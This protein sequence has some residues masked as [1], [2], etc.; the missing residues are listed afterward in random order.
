[1]LRYIFKNW[2][3][4]FPPYPRI[5]TG[6]NQL[7][8]D[9]KF[10]KSCL[11][12]TNINNHTNKLLGFSYDN[13]MKNSIRF[14]WRCNND[15]IE[16]MSYIHEDSKVRYDSICDIET[17]KWYKGK[18][19]F[20]KATKGVYMVVYDENDIE[21]AIHYDKALMQ[22][23]WGYLLNPYFGGNDKAPHDM[24]I[25]INNIKTSKL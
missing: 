4:S 6:I 12:E 1:M 16:L 9:F 23:K 7:T 18:I 24:K 5:H 20:S 2:H 22:I 14:G 11:Y 15:K 10:D 19:W 3:Y 17:D 25:S 21:V 8:F 13:H